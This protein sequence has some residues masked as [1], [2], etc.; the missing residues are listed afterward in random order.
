MA[1]INGTRRNDSLDGTPN[2]DII[3]AR[4]GNDR[5][6]ANGGNDVINGSRGRDTL[7]GG[8][9]RDKFV[10]SPGRDVITDFIDGQDLIGLPGRVR[11]NRLV[12][13]AGRG[14]NAGDT[15]I[16]LG[17]RQLMILEGVNS[18]QIDRSDFT[19]DL[20]PIIEGTEPDNGFNIEFDYRFDS[21]GYFNDPARR[22]ALETAGDIF[23]DLIQDEFDNIPVGIEFTVKNPS[24]GEEETIVLEE[25]IDDLLI[26]VGAQSPPFGGE[27]GAGAAANLSGWDAAGTI[28]SNRLN[29]SNFEPWVGS[30]SFLPSLGNEFSIPLTL[31]EIGHILGIGPAPIF[32]KTIGEGDGFE[33]P[34]AMAVNGGNSIPLESIEFEDRLIHVRAGFVSAEGDSSIMISPIETDRPSRVDL[35]MLA[36]IGYEIEGFEAQ[37]ETLPI[38]T[39][40]DDTIKGRILDDIID[41]KGGNDDIF[42]NLGNDTLNGDAGNDTLNGGVAHDLLNGGEGND[43]FFGDSRDD[44]FGDDTLNGEAGNDQLNGWIGNDLVNGGDGTD[45]LWGGE[46][47]DTL[48]GNKLS[49]I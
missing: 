1:R 42:G 10:L 30:I 31:H 27:E 22:A 25:E 48:N 14:V 20:T 13:S 11:F 36:D 45:T 7:T 16:S 18:N 21:T 24:T 19:N 9:G 15:V 46:G 3:I 8:S 5:V 12:I 35:A 28:F 29:G 26:F 6:S 44:A 17:G 23:E 37:G 38:A 40:G 2:T 47:N 43:V 39:E 49:R 33:G 41:G 32:S 34:N 4:Q